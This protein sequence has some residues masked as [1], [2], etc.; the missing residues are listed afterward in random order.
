M[1]RTASTPKP[2]PRTVGT[3]SMPRCATELCVSMPQRL[4]PPI[5]VPL[6]SSRSWTANRTW[7]SSS[8]SVSARS[9]SASLRANDVGRQGYVLAPD[10]VTTSEWRSWKTARSERR[11][12]RRVTE[13]PW[14]ML[15]CA[16]RG[17][18]GATTFPQT[19]RPSPGAGWSGRR[20]RPRRGLGARDGRPMGV[21]RGLRR[22]ARLG[23]DAWHLPA[24]E[25]ARRLL[26]RDAGGRV[27]VR[28][29]E[30]LGGE[31]GV[32]Q[33]VELLT[34]SDQRRHGLVVALVDDLPDLA[35]DELL[36]RRRDAVQA[37]GRLLARR[38]QHGDRPDH[39]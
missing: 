15:H 5:A 18:S 29:V 4:V 1:T 34:V 12:S 23:R 19:R 7:R 30:R 32:R 31:Q 38:R 11:T 36:R 24:G 3:S 26:A 16:A 2:R 28:L 35:V 37:Q 8:G 6:P 27:R 14:S 13:R 39:G 17:T 25:R 20:R 22:H 21:G 33:A 10:A 9:N